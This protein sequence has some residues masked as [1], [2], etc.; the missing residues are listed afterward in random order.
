VPPA[1]AATKDALRAAYP[2]FDQFNA[3]RAQFDPKGTMLNP[4]QQQMFGS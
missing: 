1:G 3:I 4:W 2:R